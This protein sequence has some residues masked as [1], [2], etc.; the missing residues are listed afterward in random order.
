MGGSSKRRT[1]G[2]R[3]Y[4]D[5]LMGLS[6]GSSTDQAV[7]EVVEVRVGDRTAW[8]GSVTE[9]TTIQIDKPELFGGESGEG[10][11]QGP[12]HIMM[13]E[14]TQVAPQGLRALLGGTSPGFRGTLTAFFSGMISAMNPYPKPW[15][16]R[17]R[18]RMRGW[19]NGVWYP[20]KVAINLAGGQ[21]HAMNGVH[22]IVEGLTNRDWGR[23]FP[24]DRLD[25]ESYRVAADKLYAEGFGICLR[26]A[27]QSSL[28]EFM[29]TVMDHIGASHYVHRRTG[30]L[31]LSLIRGDYDPEALPLYDY[32]SGLLSIEEDGLATPDTA[33]NEVVVI[34]RDPITN[35]DRPVREYNLG[36]IQAA[37][38]KH[39]ETV[40]YPG[41]PTYGLASRVGRRDLAAKEQGLRRLR[42]RFDRRG[43]DIHPA[44]L[45]RISAPDHGIDQMVLRAGRIEESPITDGE[46]II[47]ALQDVFGLPA[48]ALTEEQP[49]EWTPPDRETRP[50]L[51]QVAL[52]FSYRDMVTGLGPGDL[53]EVAPESGWVGAFG[54]RPSGLALN[55]NL[56]TRTGSADYA[57]ADVGDWCPTA[58]LAQDLP[59]GEGSLVLQ[60]GIDL[61]QVGTGGAALLGS[62][63]VRVD[64][65]DAGAG[66]CTVA[67]GC[68]D[69]VPVLHLA[70]TRIWFYDGYE[71]VDQSEY[72]DG[73]TVNLKLLTRTSS[74]LLELAQAPTGVVTL[75]QRH[76]R[77]YP[78]ARVRLNG[79]YWPES[80]VGEIQVTWAHRD[81]LLQAD[82][83]VPWTDGN[84]GPEDG[85]TYQV[86]LYQGGSLVSQETTATT[87]QT[88]TPPADG[89]YTVRVVSVRDGLASWQA[90]EHSFEWLQTSARITEDGA[91]RITEDGQTRRI[92]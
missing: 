6:R 25:V 13:G 16:F 12:L 91:L 37:G 38:V 66:T 17:T 65:L 71:A 62:E 50:A 81:R 11:V 23:G 78:P 15:K 67:R 3:Y 90:Y 56:M 1:V 77:P 33:V 45:F 48:T 51:D 53:S 92:E 41:I 20:E 59:P 61:S 47:T 26:Y 73:E 24:I 10:G 84:I 14:P 85:T 60:D 87:S 79:E 52:E 46:I 49:T 64:V 8:K 58:V 32:S 75:D 74:G 28:S 88:I 42:L 39:S 19:D 44:G 22:I 86:S 35:K 70:G 57:E 2:Y 89:T 82:V 31:T 27:R 18:R 72:V 40:N 9:S 36:A 55:F 5:I 30:L 54:A 21:I 7:D 43:Y 29:Q 69:T 80:L 34:Y 63:M 76:Y 68:G 4:F 83:L